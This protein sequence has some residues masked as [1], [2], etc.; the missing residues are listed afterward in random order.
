MIRTTTYVRQLHWAIRSTSRVVLAL[1][2]VVTISCS[3]DTFKWKTKA[4]NKRSSLIIGDSLLLIEGISKSSTYGYSKDNPIKLGVQD[5]T[6]AIYY[7]EKYLSTLTGPNGEAIVYRRIKSCCPFKTVNS[8]ESYKNLAVLE[9]YS[10]LH[11]G[12]PE[13]LI[14][15]INF[16]DEGTVLAPKGFSFKKITKHQ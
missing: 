14:L 7:P 16:F 6:L 12:L 11:Q 5:L 4:K 10:V 2:F 8:N 9:V 15:Y 1:T 13:P 3:H